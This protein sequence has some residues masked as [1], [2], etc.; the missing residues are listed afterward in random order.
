[1]PVIEVAAVSA[2]DTL[3]E[4]ADTSVFFLTKEQ[5][6]VI[7]IQTVFDNRN[8]WISF[9]SYVVKMFQVPGT[10]RRIERDKIANTPDCF[11]ARKNPKGKKKSFR[12][13]L[14]RN[15]V[16]LIYAAIKDVIDVPCNE[17]FFAHSSI[18][19]FPGTGYLGKTSD[20]CKLFWS[21]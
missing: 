7:W 19:S 14:V 20:V 5:M 18:S 2:L 10:W 16:P 21:Y 3:H 13:F 17:W 11:F 6:K 1:M 9:R 15:D 8:K 12:V 4:F